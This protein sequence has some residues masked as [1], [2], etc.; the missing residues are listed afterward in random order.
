MCSQVTMKDLAGHLAATSD[1]LLL[2]NLLR[3]KQSQ[4]RC[5]FRAQVE[6]GFA[7]STASIALYNGCAIPFQPT[8]YDHTAMTHI[9]PSLAGLN[10][11]RD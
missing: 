10:R 6:H 7:P 8:T 3:L 9:F 5:I 2:G 4:H 11:L 1:S